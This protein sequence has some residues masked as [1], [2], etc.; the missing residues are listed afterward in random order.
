VRPHLAVQIVT[1]LVALA[2]LP[3]PASAQGFFDWFNQRQDDRYARQNSWS[4]QRQ[5]SWS[6]QRQEW[7]GHQQRYSAPQVSAYSDPAAPIDTPRYGAPSTPSI[8]GGGR[9]VA[10]C[11]RLCDGRHF[12]M[13][14]HSNATS[15]QLCNAFC[16][17]A[18]T[19]VFNGSQVDHAV[20]ANG[21]RYANLEN[22]FVYREKIVPNCT[23]NGKD[24]FGLAKIDVASDP[25][26]K[27][28]DIVATGDNQKAALVAAANRKVRDTLTANA[29]LSRGKAAKPADP[30]AEERPED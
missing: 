27:P 7:S 6:G 1:I 9:Y 21:A 25:T 29:A 28:G 2:A 10:Y 3:A 5:N 4:G 30:D 16:P 14:R 15:I 20:A 23:C 17:A 18:K 19:E 13:Q 22:A 12:P 11:V 26:L 24:A 8:G